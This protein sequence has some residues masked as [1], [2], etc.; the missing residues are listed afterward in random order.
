MKSFAIGFA[1]LVSAM[2]AASLSVA[3]FKPAASTLQKFVSPG[4]LSPRHAYIGSDCTTCHEPTIGATAAKCTACHA[5]ATRL[6]GRQP[7]AFHASVQEC[8]TCHV[9]HQRSSIRPTTMDHVALAKVGARTLASAAAGGDRDSTAT[10]TS[11]QT[12]L[13]LQSPEQLDRASTRESL[14]CAGCHDRR[15]PHSKRFGNDCGQCHRLESWNIPSYQHPSPESKQCVQCHEPPPSHRMMHFSM[16]SQKIAGKESANVEQCF[17]CHNT[18][19]WNDI[20]GL[21]FYKHH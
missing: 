15:D 13:R 18:T 12:W 10:L 2:I 9:E 6:L 17:E 19:S 8:A 1:L 14:N 4:P 11:L 20:V 5:N 7:T 21:G 16:I 3:Y